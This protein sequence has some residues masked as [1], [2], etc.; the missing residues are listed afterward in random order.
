MKQSEEES[1]GLALIKQ[2]YAGG[3][4]NEF[5]ALS[6][7][8]NRIY[9]FLT[10]ALFTRMFGESAVQITIIAYNKIHMKFRIGQ[11]Q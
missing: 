10:D 4:G 6:Q 1:H 2:Q 5:H 9:S 7:G 8:D 11:W 3:H